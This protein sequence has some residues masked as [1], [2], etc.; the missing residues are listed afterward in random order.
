[1]KS[2]KRA[3]AAMG[4]PDVAALGRAITACQ[5]KIAAIKEKIQAAS[6]AAE[7]VEDPKIPVPQQSGSLITKIFSR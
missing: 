1:M 3:L 5:Q 7:N 4:L 2:L 6:I